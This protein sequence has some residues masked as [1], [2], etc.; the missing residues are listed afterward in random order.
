MRNSVVGAAPTVT[1]HRTLM[2]SGDTL[3][4]RPL[5]GRE[6]NI[7]QQHSNGIEF[8]LIFPSKGDNRKITVSRDVKSLR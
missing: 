2:F 4:L 5:W 7:K 8:V 6:V 3:L 1:Y